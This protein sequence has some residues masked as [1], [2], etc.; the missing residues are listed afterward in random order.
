MDL[1]EFFEDDHVAVGG[2]TGLQVSED[3]QIFLD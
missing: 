3:F 2:P 1:D